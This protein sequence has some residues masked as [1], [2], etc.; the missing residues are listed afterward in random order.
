[1]KGKVQFNR[2]PGI[3]RSPSTLSQRTKL[4]RFACARSIEDKEPH[5]GSSMRFRLWGLGSSAKLAKLGHSGDSPG[6]AAVRG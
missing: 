2:I 3:R 5:K 1:M 6:K 4:G